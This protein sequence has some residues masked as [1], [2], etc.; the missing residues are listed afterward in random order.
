MFGLR[1]FFFGYFEYTNTLFFFISE[2][3]SP[4]LKCILQE[5][6]HLALF[7]DKKRDNLFANRVTHVKLYFSL[8]L[9]FYFCKY[10]YCEYRTLILF[11]FGGK[12][13]N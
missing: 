1:E 10:S 6:F 8:L 13:I 5:E 2:R 9:L 4:F 11:S 3:K 12:F 7:K